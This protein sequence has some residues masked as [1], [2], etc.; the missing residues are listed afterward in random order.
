VAGR[1]GCKAAPS[2]APAQ[3]GNLGFI[4][5]DARD[6]LAGMSKACCRN[7]SHVTCAEYRNPHFYRWLASES[8]PRPDG[9]RAWARRG[10]MASSGAMLCNRK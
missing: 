3:R 7:E 10:V 4:D 2:L 5:F 6:M 9:R 8:R 1:D